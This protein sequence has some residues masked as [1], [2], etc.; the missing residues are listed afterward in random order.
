MDY[1]N[2]S[3]A[4]FI[5]GSKAVESALQQVKSSRIPLPLARQKVYR[6]ATELLCNH[7]VSLA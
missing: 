1:I 3:H 2:T 7:V 5:G 6:H 4:N